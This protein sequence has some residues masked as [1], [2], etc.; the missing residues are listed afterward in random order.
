MLCKQDFDPEFCRYLGNS[1]SAYHVYK[2]NYMVQTLAQPKWT[3]ISAENGDDTAVNRQVRPFLRRSFSFEHL[4]T[5]PTQGAACA[6]F[7]GELVLYAGWTSTWDTIRNDVHI[8]RPSEPAPGQTRKRK[9][10]ALP[11]SSHRPTQRPVPATE[12]HA[13]RQ[14]TLFFPAAAPRTANGAGAFVRRSDAEF[15]TPP[16]TLHG[17]RSWEPS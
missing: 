5:E 2:Q 11:R 7:R 13:A 9:Q 16:L 6:A 1:T 14:Q 17:N 4:I 10:A 3:Q 8:L 15:I 12:P